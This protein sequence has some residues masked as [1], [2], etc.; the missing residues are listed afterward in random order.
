MVGHTEDSK[1]PDEEWNPDPLPRR[2]AGYPERLI[3]IT[4]SVILYSTKGVILNAA[5][6]RKS[7]FS[8]ADSTFKIA[9][10]QTVEKCPYPAEQISTSQIYTTFFYFLNSI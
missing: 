2:L 7:D 3:P 8:I 10:P 6:P 9:D 5:P 4:F 1:T